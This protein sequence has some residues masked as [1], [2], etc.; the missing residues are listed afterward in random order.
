MSGYYDRLQG[1]DRLLRIR[2]LR[3]ALF[4]GI[5]ALSVLL[6]VLRMGSQG[7][8]IKPL[9]LPSGSSCGT[10]RSDMHSGTV[11]DT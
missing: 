4:A 3:K 5:V 8:S 10:W 6:V 2:R 11:S 1:T 7:A 9:F